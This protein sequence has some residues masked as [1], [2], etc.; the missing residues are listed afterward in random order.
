MQIT[1]FIIC[2]AKKHYI[3]PKLSP[4]DVQRFFQKFQMNLLERYSEQKMDKDIE[5]SPICEN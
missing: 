3:K 5:I 4:N 2:D 1:K